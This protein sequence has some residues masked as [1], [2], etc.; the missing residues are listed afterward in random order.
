MASLWSLAAGPVHAADVIDVSMGYYKDDNRLTVNTPSLSIAKDILEQ[1][2]LSIKY[3]YETFEKEAPSGAADAVTGA[4][5]VSGGS[6][7][8]YDEIRHEIIAGL[9]HRIGSTSLAAGY[10]YGNEDDFLS[11]AFSVA[12]T[13]EL[14]RK[15]VTLTLLYGKTFDQIFKLD[16]PNDDFPKDK[17][18]DT[19]TIAATQI[20]TP[21]LLV[22][23]GYS[24]S[25]VTG[26]QS[27]PLRKLIVP[28][29]IGGELVEEQH[30]DLRDRHTLFLRARQYATSRT[31]TDVNV[32]YY[33]DDWGV[34]AF[35]V[36][37]RVERYLTDSA[38]IRFRYRWYAQ[39]AAD[40]YQPTYQ[41]K[42]EFMTA[43]ARL[44]SFDTHTVGVGLRLLGDTIEDWSVFM[45]Y[46]RYVETNDGVQAN[47]FQATLT[48]P[49]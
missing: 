44:R 9:S 1:T 27:L 13:Q 39:S 24:L 23:G 26:F 46:D 25:H 28:P 32:S 5:T 45:T 8:G 16:P 48:I 30:P 22:S 15:N 31:A 6:G 34:E 21:T 11:N 47:V 17:D 37:P 18:T 3:T 19:Y 40:F 35:M 33:F 43:D 42:Q 38:T 10:F 4:T 7:S 2:T 14:F 29:A 20:L 36:E 41:V 49:Y 12:L